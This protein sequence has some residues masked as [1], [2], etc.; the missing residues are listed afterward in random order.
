MME[1]SEKLFYAR[2]TIVYENE[3]F[4]HNKLRRWVVNCQTSLL[5]INIYVMR[6]YE[7]FEYS[8]QPYGDL[9]WNP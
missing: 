1:T 9:N 5:K 7:I 8:T 3:R 6:W 4:L 2:M